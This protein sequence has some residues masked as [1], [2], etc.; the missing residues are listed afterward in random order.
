MKKKDEELA[1]KLQA[2]EDYAGALDMSS[3]TGSSSSRKVGYDSESSSGSRSQSSS[4]RRPPPIVGLGGGTAAVSVLP[5]STPQR[6]SASTINTQ[7]RPLH[8]TPSLKEIMEEEY[9]LE[10]S[11]KDY[12]S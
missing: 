5:L 10:L 3:E 8:P 12:V 11:Q 4:P 1:R 7:A 9:T 6:P 2:E